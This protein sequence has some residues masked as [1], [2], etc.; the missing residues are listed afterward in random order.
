M[1]ADFTG[2]GAEGERELK[3]KVTGS[4]RRPASK[5]TFAERTEPLARALGVCAGN[6]KLGKG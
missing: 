2:R 4:R 3:C 6:S 1:H 5:I